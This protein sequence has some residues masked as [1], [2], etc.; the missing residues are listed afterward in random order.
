VVINLK[1]AEALG[2]MIPE[3]FL[4]RVDEGID[5]LIEHL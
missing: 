1:I 3:S 5:Q 4:V 2:L